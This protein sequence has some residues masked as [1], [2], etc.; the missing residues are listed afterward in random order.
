[1]TCCEIAYIILMLEVVGLILDGI[2]CF[3]F[4][5]S[6]VFSIVSSYLPP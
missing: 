2:L 5:F 4:V 1:M 6:I 3:C